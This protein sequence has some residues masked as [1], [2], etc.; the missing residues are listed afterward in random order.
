MQRSFHNVV[1]TSEKYNVHMR[2]GALACAINRVAEI[3][4]L[5]GVYP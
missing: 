3:S 5:R 1:G 2:T 4:R